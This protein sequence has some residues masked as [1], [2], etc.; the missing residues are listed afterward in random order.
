[1]I[2]RKSVKP[3]T[4]E[5]VTEK[6]I[7]L[8][9]NPGDQCLYSVYSL[10]WDAEYFPNPRKFDPERF[11]DENKHKIK[12]GTYVPFGVGPRN[13]IGKCIYAKKKSGNCLF[14]RLF[15]GSRFATLE[16]KSL[17]FHLIKDFQVVPNEKTDI[18]LEL[19]KDRFTLVPKNGF[20]LS[21]K[22][23]ALM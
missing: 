10:H 18:P 23:R 5:N 20:H 3:Y 2:D 19:L 11:S 14:N 4:I 22:K 12:P 16:M 1:M 15:E 7:T 6:G 21:F 9:L 8:H 17:L 13:C